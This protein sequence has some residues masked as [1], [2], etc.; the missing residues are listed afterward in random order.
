MAPGLLTFSSS[1]FPI[2]LSLINIRS[3]HFG[4]MKA[5]L[6]LAFVSAS[7]VL[8]ADR[9]PHKLMTRVESSAGTNGYDGNVCVLP[10]VDPTLLDKCGH[11]QINQGVS[12]SLHLASERR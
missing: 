3:F 2:P 10:E 11:G 1:L 7:L 12:F 9:R 6:L 8:A 4:T 5:S